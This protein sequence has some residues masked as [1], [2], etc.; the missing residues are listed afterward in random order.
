MPAAFDHDFAVD[1]NPLDSLGREM[2]LLVGG[3][4]LNLLEIEDHDIRP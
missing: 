4:I 3:A 1:Q 2:G